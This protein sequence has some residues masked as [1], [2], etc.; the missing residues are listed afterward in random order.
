[1]GLLLIGAG[2]PSLSDTTTPSPTT[3]PGPVVNTKP[4][5]VPDTD[6]DDEDVM[7][8]EDFTLSAEALGN[9]QVKFSWEVPDDMDVTSDHR[10]LLVRSKDED[11]EH[12][13]KNFWFRRAGTER[14][15]TWLEQPTGTYHYRVCL[16][17]DDM[18]STYSNDVEVEV[19]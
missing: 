9:G 6:D 13:G 3:T 10:F 12:D 17:K 1:M 16:M 14:A 2:C 15:T 7:E 11:P 18:C 19:K 5:T 4:D 8:N